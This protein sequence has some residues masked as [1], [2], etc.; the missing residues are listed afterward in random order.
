MEIRHLLET[1]DL[2]AVSRVYEE[3]WRA[4][5][6]GI[7]PQE[8]LDNIPEGHWIPYL[9]DGRSSAL[10]LVEEGQ[11]IETTS[12]CKS[13]FPEYGDFGEIISI[14]LLPQSMGKGYG[15][16]LL[17]AARDELARLGFQK[18]FLWVLEEN[19]RARRFY[20]KAGFSFSGHCLQNHIGGKALRELQYRYCAPDHL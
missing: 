3:S 7:V 17:E 11:I 15:R 16:P 6:R 5:Y 2:G 1:D 10:V 19:H 13:R 20:E 18:V 4:A 14:Y 8:Y 9:R 12:Y